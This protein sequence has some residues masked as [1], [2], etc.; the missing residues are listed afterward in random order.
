M[1]IRHILSM[2]AGAGAVA[3]FAF[4]VAAAVLPMDAPTTVG[5]LQAVCTGVGS[6]K[7]DPRWADYPIRLEFSNSAAQFLA[8][9]NVKVMDNTGKLLAEFDCSGPWVLLQLP[10]GTYGVTAAIPQQNLGPKTVRF[11]TPST[12]QKRVGIQFPS[13]PANE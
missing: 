11:E 3:F 7:D 1:S 9:E 8:G 2:T 13:A 6:A 4:P 5:S 10:K 12:G